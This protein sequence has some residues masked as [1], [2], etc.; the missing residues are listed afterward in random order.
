MLLAVPSAAS[1]APTA[2]PEHFLEAQA[3][4]L[5]N[6]K[7]APKTRELCYSGYAALHSGITR[8]SLWTAE[9][10]TRERLTAAKGLERN[11]TFHA[12]P[13][14]PQ[15]ERAELADYRGSGFDRGHLAPSGDMPDPQAQDESFSLANMVP[16]NAD[17][18]RNLWEGIESS[19][20][21]LARRNGELY[22]VT[23]PFYQGS[24]IQ[25]IR[26]RVLVPTHLFKAVYDVRQR[27]AAAYLV[28]NAPGN[29]YQRISIA[30]LEELTGIAVFPGLP[31]TQRDAML[32]LPEPRPHGKGGRKAKPD[33]PGF[34]EMDVLRLLKQLAR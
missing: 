10:L 32:D 15:D 21:N 20:R 27:K 2:C 24:S 8:T 4:D 23:G 17:N 25:R 1:A 11:N 22:V 13:N 9:R 12:D 5:V 19:V 3:P 14:L 33:E 6:A 31:E 18:N 29:S 7:L 26:G 34:T 16:Q 28:E 30:D